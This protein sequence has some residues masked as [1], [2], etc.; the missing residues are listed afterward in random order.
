M[1]PSKINEGMEATHALRDQLNELAETQIWV[2]HVADL[3]SG[4]ILTFPLNRPVTPLSRAE[5]MSRLGPLFDTSIFGG[6]S[7]KLSPKM[8]YQPSPEA[9]LSAERPDFY[10]ADY[11]AIVWQPPQNSG[12]QPAPRGMHFF[13]EASPEWRSVVSISLS[14]KAWPGTTGHVRMDHTWSIAPSVQIPI[15]DTFAEHTIDLTFVPPQPLP[16]SEFDLWVLAGVEKLI[17]HS[18]RFTAQP[19]LEAHS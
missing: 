14:G 16:R 10:W 18:I 4:K 1:N 11:D 5:R 15:G 13:F 9:W 2:H 19:V 6:P 12:V 3:N 7:Y 8:P 17:F